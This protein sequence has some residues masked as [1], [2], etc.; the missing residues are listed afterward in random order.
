MRVTAGVSRL[1]PRAAGSPAPSGPRPRRRRR[2]S[3]VAALYAL[4]A[5][6]LVGLFLVYPMISVFYYALTRWGGLGPPQFIGLDNFVNLF[7]D[8]VFLTSI[9]NN[10]IFALTVPV[11]L[12][13]ALVLAYLIY[14]RVPGWRFFRWAFFLPAVYST[15]VIG[16][17]TTYALEPNGP[18]SG[19][20]RAVGVKSLASPWLLHTDTSLA[21]IAL[22]IVFA[23]FGYSVII[24][25]S[26]MAAIDPNLAEAGRLDGAGFW[27]ILRR[28]YLPNLRRVLELVL[29]INTITALAYTFTYVYVIT[30]GGP[31]TSTFTTDYYMYSSGFTNEALGY[32]AAMAVVLIIVIAI[33]GSV[34]IRVMTRGSA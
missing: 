2:R 18:V 9:E 12:V 29:V 5:V 25:L 14:E 15:V 30:N 28:I 7:H 32:A 3:R 17:I 11:I 4:P 10:G 19:F 34:Q 6:G 31:G 24:M 16:I 13:G 8:P 21:T 33:V 26:G 20:F 27:Q 1:I 22:V 23:N